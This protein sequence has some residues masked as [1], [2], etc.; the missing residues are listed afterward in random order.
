MEPPVSDPMAPGRKPAA[1]AAPDPLDD[2]PVVWSVF[3]GLRAGG[4]GKSK[5]GPP[6]ANSCVE[7]LP[8][9][10]IPAS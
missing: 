9:S 10:T 4:H 3:Q 1:T 8:S 6:W 5:E 2:P 7:S